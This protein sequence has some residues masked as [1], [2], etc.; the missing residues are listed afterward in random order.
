MQI[1]EPGY[2]VTQLN[3]LKFPNQLHKSVWKAQHTRTSIQEGFQ[4]PCQVIQSLPMS[5]VSLV[6]HGQSINKFWHNAKPADAA[7]N[8]SLDFDSLSVGPPLS[9][10]QK[11]LGH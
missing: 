4:H 2:T 8:T 11:Y 1:Y 5:P 7:E 3:F 9:I 10:K 6:V